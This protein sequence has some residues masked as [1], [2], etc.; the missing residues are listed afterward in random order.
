M[1]MMQEIYERLRNAA[2][3]VCDQATA[4]R[5]INVVD[6]EKL[7]E[8]ACVDEKVPVVRREKEEGASK[9]IPVIGTSE[10]DALLANFTRIYLE[11]TKAFQKLLERKGLG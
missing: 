8:A 2:M 10:Y 1:K 5:S 6:I 11:S 3:E 4:Y 9:V 7:R